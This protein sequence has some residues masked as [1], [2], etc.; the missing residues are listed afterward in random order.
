MNSIEYR[1]KAGDT[2]SAIARRH[3]VTVDALSRLNGI[4]DV[5]RIWVG[6]LLRITRENPPT[7]SRPPRTRTYRVRAGDT[8][9]AIA[10]RHNVTVEALSQASGLGDSDSVKIGMVLKIPREAPP[11]PPAPNPF[12]EFKKANP[13][14]H[15]P[16]AELE[17]LS[18]DDPFWRGPKPLAIPYLDQPHMFKIEM[19]S[20]FG[21]DIPNNAVSALLRDLKSGKF[22]GPKY[23]FSKDL[24]EDTVAYYAKGVMTLSEPLI[25]RAQSSPEKRF[26]LFLGMVHEFGHHLDFMI[27]NEY[28]SV[29]GSAPGEEGQRFLTDFVRFNDSL[30]AN[31]D[32]AT[33]H[34]GNKAHG[35][36]TAT[37][38]T[39]YSV[40]VGEINSEARARYLLFAVDELEDRG[41]VIIN[42]EE[43]TVDFF[44][45]R[46]AGAVHEDITKSAA[47]IANV[48]Y[49]TRLDEGCAWPDVPCAG[50]GVETCYYKTWR[51]METPGT[52]AYRSHFGDLQYWH[53]MA[54]TGAWTNQ[55]VVEKNH[56]SGERVV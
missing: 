13:F 46:G 32:F 22:P 2:L 34:W 33:F 53:S 16:L 23:Q 11:T 39:V 44:K 8:L 24:S 48:P 50:N 15:N 35:K 27:R 47:E 9:P 37:K 25:R 12:A 21:D 51:E 45:I 14:P 28:S 3:H 56:C 10:R 38:S 41:E 20:C 40:K 49:D 31:F 42:G 4:S 55:Q 7:P 30:E 43:I 5:N 52:L 26:T 18:V 19:K 29:G 54:P 36:A 17:P 6:Q 1:V